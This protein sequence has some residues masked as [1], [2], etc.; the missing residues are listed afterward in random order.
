[1]IQT[2]QQSVLINL[3][4]VFFNQTFGSRDRFESF[5]KTL[6]GNETPK[7]Y[8]YSIEYVIPF[9]PIGIIYELRNGRKLIRGK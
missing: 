8:V 9:Y 4:S 5:F 3:R 7:L 6:L 1:M 2:K